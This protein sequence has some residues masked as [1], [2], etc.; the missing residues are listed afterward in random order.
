VWNRQP[1]AFRSRAVI[2]ADG[3]VAGTT[4]EKKFDMDFNYLKKVWG[5]HPLLVSLANTREPLVNRPGNAQ[6]HQGAAAAEAIELVSPVFDSVL[7]R[8][9]TDFSLTVNF[10]RWSEQGVAFVFGFDAHP[11]LVALAQEV[12][13][14][15]GHRD[16]KGSRPGRY[17]AWSLRLLAYGNLIRLLFRSMQTTATL[18]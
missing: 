9:D 15:D 18:T 12:S 17:A 13:A 4:G 5:Y 8:G 3:T 1:K 11:K 14:S 6:S 2:D 10:D 7:L 16:T